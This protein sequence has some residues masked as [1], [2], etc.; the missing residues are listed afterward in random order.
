MADYNDVL[1]K[2]SLLGPRL[3]MLVTVLKL[4]TGL[5]ISAWPSLETIQELKQLSSEEADE[6][7]PVRVDGQVLHYR[8]GN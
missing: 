8:F 6:N 5:S 2:Y 7:Y 3:L 4:L 1:M